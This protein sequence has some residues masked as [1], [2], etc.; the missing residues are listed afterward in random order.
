MKPADCEWYSTWCERGIIYGPWYSNEGGHRKKHHGLHDGC[1][2]F[3]DAEGGVF[4]SS[5]W[6]LLLIVLVCIAEITYIVKKGL[7]MMKQNSKNGQS[8][9]II[10]V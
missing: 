9:I 8:L 5:P 3:K 1:G 10:H 2:Q 4:T 6:V 7:M